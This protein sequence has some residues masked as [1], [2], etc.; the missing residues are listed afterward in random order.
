MQMGSSVEGAYGQYVIREELKE[1]MWRAQSCLT[2]QNVV[3]KSAEDHLLNKERR[4]L[5]RFGHVPSLRRLIDEVAEPPMLV[6]EY[7]ETNLLTESGEKKLQPSDVK[8]VAKT[9]LQALAALHE[10]GIVH[11]DI[12]P[13][14]ILVNRGD[15]NH[16][17]SDIKLADC[18]DSTH[19][20]DVV[21]D[22]IIWTG[23]LL[24]P[25]DH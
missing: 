18:G 25:S 11:T 1:N 24:L 19:I 21:E 13:D 6:L 2:Q 23:G 12:K 10:E 3:V 14:N 16:R 8:I 4:T 22:H 9:V 20:D 17:F 5:R 7:L 15:H